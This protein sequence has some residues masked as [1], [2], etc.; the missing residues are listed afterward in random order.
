MIRI[1]NDEGKMRYR[2][3]TIAREY[4]SGGAEIAG[5][6]ARELDWRLL[7]KDLIDEISRKE[8]VPASEVAAFDEKV[9]PWIHRITR[10]IWG[11]GADGISPIAPMDIFDAQKAARLARRTIEEAYKMGECVIVGRGSQCVLRNREDVFHAF[12]YA[13]R[14]DRIRKIRDRVKPDTD[15][16]ALIRTMDAQ[17]VEYVRLHYRENWLNPY[18]YDL[19]I[20][21]KNQ[22]EKVARLI[23]SAM[24]MVPETVSS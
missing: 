24:K 15:V 10:S 22:S 7:D 5:I 23:I 14:E 21:S 8:K 1:H 11:V 9:D 6:I 18:L 19:M 20:N 13:T 17:R 3:L 16:D 4:G 12:I 2:V